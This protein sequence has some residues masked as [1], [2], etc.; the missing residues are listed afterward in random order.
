MN[1]AD[2]RNFKTALRNEWRRQLLQF[3]KYIK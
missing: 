1:P 3:G 2:K